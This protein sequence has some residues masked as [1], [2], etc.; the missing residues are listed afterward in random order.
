MSV[1]MSA[2][3]STNKE[4]LGYTRQG[5]G[6]HHVVQSDVLVLELILDV[7]VARAIVGGRGPAID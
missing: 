5:D 4:D 1:W 3:R 2:T 6:D 7:D